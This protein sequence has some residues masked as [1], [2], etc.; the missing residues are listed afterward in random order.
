MPEKSHDAKNS[1]KKNLY[2]AIAK[3]MVGRYAVYA[4]NLVSM[5]ILARVFSPDTFGTIASVTVLLAFFQ[6]LA[7]GGIAPAIINLRTLVA[8]D[9][10]GIFSFTLLLGA[11]LSLVLIF[12]TPIIEVFYRNPELFKIIP[13]TSFSILFYSAAILPTGS[14]LRDQKFKKI[15]ISG[16]AAETISTL[17]ALAT[18]YL[19]SDSLCALAGKPLT[20]SLVNFI[21]LHYFSKDTSFGRAAPGKSLAS[22]STLMSFSGYQLG[23]NFVNYFTRNLDNVLVAKYMGSAELGTYDRAYQ[24]MRYPL[25]LLTFAMTPAIQPIVKNHIENTILVERIHREFTLKLSIAG[26]IISCIIILFSKTIVEILLGDEWTTVVP[27]IKVLS[28]SIPVQVVLS[29]SGSFF[30]SYNRTDLLFKSGILS[31]AVTAAFI[32]W[33]VAKGSIIDLAWAVVISFHINFIQAYLLL[34]RYILKRQAF[35][36][37][38]HMLPSWIVTLI[39]AIH[40]TS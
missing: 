29:T 40:L 30:Q 9:R 21:A 6:M 22:I 33:G 35:L 24:I 20:S 3:S 17:L 16:I 14:L 38:T 2:S 7:E 36:F 37:F 10:N 5:M 31:S 8:K 4:V 12:A 28:L 11:T 23:F 32:I 39:L 34:Y 15:A 27:V 26:S 25:M 19:T 1:L 18:L 13:I